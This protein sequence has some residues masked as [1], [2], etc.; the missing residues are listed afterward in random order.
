[1]SSGWPLLRTLSSSGGD[2]GTCESSGA[3]ASAE[4]HER[5]AL[6]SVSLAAAMTTALVARGVPEPTAAIAGE[7]GALA[8]KRGYAEWFEDDHDAKDELAR[9]PRRPWRS[10][11]R[12]AHRWADRANLIRSSAST[13]HRHNPDE[14][15]LSSANPVDTPGAHSD[16]ICTL[17]LVIAEDPSAAHSGGD[18]R[19]GADQVL[20]RAVIRLPALRRAERRIGPADRSAARIAGR[21]QII[22]YWALAAFS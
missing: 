22:R 18:A 19:A 8:F 15:I 5:Y 11:A 3:A 12:R 21:A 10:C 14:R 9:T 1:M 2:G 17:G 16:P 20:L 7:L 6:K 13:D 4:L